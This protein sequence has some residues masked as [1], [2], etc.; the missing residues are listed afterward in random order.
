MQLAAVVVGL[1][2]F[3]A[4]GPV[5]VTF[6]SGNGTPV[7]GTTS[8]PHD[9]VLYYPYTI[10]VNG[11]HMTVAC[12]DFAGHVYDGESWLANVNTFSDAEGTIGLSGGKFAAS[13]PTTMDVQNY[14]EAAYL[15]YQ[16][17]PTPPDGNEVNAAINYALWDLFDDS[18]PS[19]NAVNGDTTTSSSYWLTQ[20]GLNYSTL[21][22]S[23]LSRIEIF[24]PVILAPEAPGARKFNFLQSSS[25]PQEFMGTVPEPATLVLLG[26]GLLGLAFVFKRR[27]Q[28]RLQAQS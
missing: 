14:E 3:A 27:W 2:A 23:Q 22:W 28:P 13:T 26:T 5:T 6:V 20:A 16:F 1:A 4:A 17:Q 21:S 10:S 7:S 19:L 25:N 15:F 8:P 18:A 9:K 24:T 12:D 11:S